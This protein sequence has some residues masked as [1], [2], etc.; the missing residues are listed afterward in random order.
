[1]TDVTLKPIK[2]T[3]KSA[4]QQVIVD[5]QVIGEVWR[6]KTSTVVSKL[7]QP[8]RSEMKWRWFG[9][10]TGDSTVIGGTRRSFAG[11]GFAKKESVIEEMR[12]AP[13]PESK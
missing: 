3:E 8:I 7:M 13:Q 1:M 5:G 9:S 2:G 6:K 12:Q 11:Y 10:R 4:H